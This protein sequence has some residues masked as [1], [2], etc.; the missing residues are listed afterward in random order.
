ML[1]AELDLW[2]LTLRQMLAPPKK[3]I[4]EALVKDQAIDAMVSIGPNFFYTVVLPCSLWFLDRGKKN[5]KRADKVLFLDARN[6][7][8]QVDR[9]HREFTEQQ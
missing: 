5:S 1:T 6:I 4:R 9:A 2:W 7:F 8:R 3:E